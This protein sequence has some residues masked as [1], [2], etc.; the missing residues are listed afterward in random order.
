[1][2]A[3]ST[4]LDALFATRCVLCNELGASCCLVCWGALSFETREVQREAVDAP[5]IAG[6][7]GG[8]ESGDG[9][10]L[11]GVASIDFGP[12]VGALV[13]AFKELGRAALARQ[14]AEAMLPCV[15]LL[16]LSP[17]EIYHLVPV[18]SRVS[19][20]QERGFSP[21]AVVTAA[22]LNRLEPRW[23]RPG[24]T[25]AARFRPAA[26]LVWRVGE[27]ADQASLGQNERK[28]NLRGTMRAS[29]KAS[30][31]RV[32]LVDDIVTTG[33]S[34]FETARALEVEGAEI[35]GFVTFSETILRNIGKSHTNESKK[36]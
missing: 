26:R 13:H 28:Q 9:R 18:P 20:T 16:R 7:A 3:L 29:S 10:K 14:F 35:V 15:E 22:L 32:I 1:M 36:V 6:P 4:F 25:L 27:A 23:G 21:A 24:L 33:S 34:L 30:G 19:S 8:R 2:P 5:V 11:H 31:K 17:N 12:Q